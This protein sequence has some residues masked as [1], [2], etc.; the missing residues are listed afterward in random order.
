MDDDIPKKVEDFF[1]GYPKRTYPKDQIVIFSGE[2]PEKVFYIVSGKITQYDISY[3]GDE[4]VTNIFKTP[5]F[6]PMSWAI[7]GTPNTY[8]YK[9]EEET[10]IHVA[11]PDDVLAFLKQNPDVMYNL[12]S[13][14]YKG[15]D[16]ILAR[17]VHLM[18]GSA[19]SR[20]IYELV[21]EAR[22]FGEKG[23]DNSYTLN[24]NETD[25]AAHAGLARETISR[26]VKHLKERE[27]IE[28]EHTRLIVKDL[29]ALEEQLGTVS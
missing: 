19:K 7:N 29:P 27:L 15:V 1:N 23:S 25:L 18:S 10:V 9:A 20:V 28:V 21:I 8:F 3:R 11:P 22:R 26:E 14:V 12:L 2:S 6:F 24:I 13:R 16:G 17:T 4:V 5:A